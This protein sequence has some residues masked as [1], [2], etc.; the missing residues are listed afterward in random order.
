[1][2]TRTKSQSSV[3]DEQ[4]SQRGHVTHD[5]RGNAVWQ[6]NTEPS[7]NQ[8]RATNLSL[9][10][11]D[12]ELLRGGRVSH[13][14]NTVATSVGYNPYESGLLNKQSRPK[15]RDLHELS[16]WIEQKNAKRDENFD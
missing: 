13:T 16:R 4:G 14:V 10:V 3:P 11:S 15:K 9:E 2:N 5:A 6:W 12:T 7:V 1:M 8:V